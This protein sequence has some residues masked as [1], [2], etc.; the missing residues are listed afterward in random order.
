MRRTVFLLSFPTITS[1][2]ILYQ[3]FLGPQDAGQ[4]IQSFIFNSRKKFD[5]Y[6]FLLKG[7]TFLS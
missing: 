1:K 5:F 4:K 6:S 2:S 3:I 7:K